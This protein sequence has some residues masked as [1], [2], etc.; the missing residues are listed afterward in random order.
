MT[1]MTICELAMNL[2]LPIT[3][4]ATVDGMNCLELLMAPPV[5]EPVDE[6]VDNTTEPIRRVRR[7]QDDTTDNTTDNTT[8]N[9]TEEVTSTIQIVVLPNI[10]PRANPG[11]STDELLSM[12]TVTLMELVEE[13]LG[14]EHDVVSVTTPVT[15]PILPVE[16]ATGHEYSATADT[17]SITIKGIET[18]N[19]G[20]VCYILYQGNQDA[21]ISD[22]ASG[23]YH[24]QP[25]EAHG[26]KVVDAAV[27]AA[28]TVTLNGLNDGTTY[29]LAYTVRSV[30]HRIYAQTS[31][32]MYVDNGI[33]TDTIV[34]PSTDEEE[35]FSFL[36]TFGFLS[37][38]LLIVFNA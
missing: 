6:P 27:D 21:Q 32:V 17:N 13:A 33:T 15:Y 26:C 38:L 29:Q 14:S 37:F 24:G 18:D 3:D 34:I 2:G 4:I 8:E 5:D 7:L 25:A 22:V 28:D 36:T 9:V 10:D 16:V 20:V 23:M 1:M 35:E 30:D 11:V 31:D 12:D 19:T